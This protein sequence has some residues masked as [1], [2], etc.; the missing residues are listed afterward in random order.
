MENILLCLIIFYLG[1]KFGEVVL[2]FRI[3]HLLSNIDEEELEVTESRT[4]IKKLVTEKVDN[5]LLLYEFGTNNFICQGSTL[6][7]LASLSKSYK[8]IKVA[9]VQHDNEFVW[10]VDGTVKKKI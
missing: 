4:E 8:N 7:E 1:Y 6:D 2:A 9:A 5:S 10:F 3:R